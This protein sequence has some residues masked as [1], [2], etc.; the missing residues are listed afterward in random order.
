MADNIITICP[1]VPES[2]PLSRANVC[3]AVKSI[4]DA[5]AEASYDRARS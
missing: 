1:V 3:R 5:A 2:A 4:T